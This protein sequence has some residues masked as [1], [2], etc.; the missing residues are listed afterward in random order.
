[1]SLV[2]QGKD[3]ILSL[4]LR[5]RI[6]ELVKDFGS[7]VAFSIDTA[8][9]SISLDLQLKGE[10]QNLEVRIS[11]YAIERKGDRRVFK[12]KEIVASSEWVDIILKRLV[13]AKPIEIPEEYAELAERLL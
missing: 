3:K 12:C 13:K 1:M 4:F 2:Q 5:A 8:Q 10:T 9:R 11:D 6:A 7:V